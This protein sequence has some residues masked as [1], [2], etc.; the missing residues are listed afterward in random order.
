MHTVKGFE[1]RLA[2]LEELA[3]KMRDPEVSLEEAMQ[4][5]EEGMALSGDLEKELQGFEHK[6]EQLTNL[7]AMDGSENPKTSMF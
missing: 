5:F 2:R 6:I 4:F 3:Q 1:E 7:P